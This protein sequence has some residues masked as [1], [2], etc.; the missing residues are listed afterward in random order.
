MTD[1]IG[2]AAEA[3]ADTDTDI[4]A[5]VTELEQQF[6]LLVQRIRNRWRE[7]A[8]QVHPEL[9][10]TGYKILSTLVWSGPTTATHLTELLAIDKS[11][12]SRTLVALDE[13]GLIERH[14]DEEDGRVRLLV[15]SPSAVSAVHERRRSRDA[16]VRR[17]LASWPQDDIPRLTGLV[18]RLVELA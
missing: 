5:A 17:E 14:I 3:S 16:E 13:L 8:A 10:P 9:S 11:V 1:A 18:R 2:L 12:L 6:A 4:D 15:A 7:A